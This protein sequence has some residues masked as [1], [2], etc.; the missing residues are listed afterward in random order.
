MAK[1]AFSATD[2][3]CDDKDNDTY[4]YIDFK[5]LQRFKLAG[6]TSDF[7]TKKFTVRSLSTYLLLQVRPGSR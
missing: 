2:D 7:Y 4:E 6:N 1:N 3:D 5:N